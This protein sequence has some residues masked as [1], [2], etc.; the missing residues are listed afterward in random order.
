M[1]GRR[2]IRVGI[3]GFGCSRQE[4]MDVEPFWVPLKGFFLAPVQGV[5]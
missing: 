4:K 3:N 2:A 1:G 5:R